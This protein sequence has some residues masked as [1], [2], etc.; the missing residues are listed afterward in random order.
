MESAFFGEQGLNGSTHLYRRGYGTQ[1]NGGSTKITR[2][3]VIRWLSNA[4]DGELS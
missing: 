2:V 1:M 4:M 3:K